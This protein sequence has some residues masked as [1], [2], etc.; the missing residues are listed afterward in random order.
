VPDAGPA[1]AAARATGFGHRPGLDGLRAWAVLAVLAFHSG[2]LRAGWVGVDVFFALSG[3]LI[4][5]LLLAEFERTG[6]VSLR[7]F[8]GRRARRLLPALAL[9]FL[10]VAVGTA[11]TPGSWVGATAA[12]VWGSATYTANWVR[13]AGDVG[14]WDQFRAPGPLEH[15]WSLA[16]EE[17]FYVVWPV[18]MV[19]VLRRWGRRGAVRLA[20]ATAVTTAAVQ[21]GLALAGAGVER[22]YVGTDTRA[23]AFA[24]GAWCVLAA[25][26]RVTP[27]SRWRRLAA[28]G[29]G[30]GLAGLL[31]ACLL[32]DGDA[33]STYLGP[34][35]ITSVVGALTV[36]A[37]AHAGDGR[38]AHVVT[39]APLR[40]IGRWSY[41]IYLYHWPVVVVLRDWE[42]APAVRFAVVAAVATLLAALSYELVEH[43]IRSGRLRLRT[44]VPSTATAIA[45]AGVATVA[46]AG[47]ALADAG[48]AAQRLDDAEVAELLAPLGGAPDDGL[49]GAADDPAGP[50]GEATVTTLAPVPVLQTDRVL[51]AGDSVPFHL[52]SA[53]ETAAAAAGLEV[54]VR[55]A[56]GCVPSPL[57]AD[58]YRAENDELCARL[59]E[60]LPR[61]LA[62]YRPATLVVYY[63]LSGPEVREG[64]RTYDACAP[65]GRSALTAQL[66]RV[67]AAADGIG[68]K[69][70]LVPPL[71]P[72]EVDFVDR[73]AQLAGWRC[74]LA[75]YDAFGAD[76]PEVQVVP[77]LDLLCPELRCRRELFGVALFRDG[78]HY[79]ADGAEAV[80]PWLLDQ[81]AV[82]PTA[83]RG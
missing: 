7:R 9:V 43:P 28:P 17:Q 23:P 77:I 44:L 8:W 19:L 27:A 52:R 25:D 72:P 41:G 59:V 75:T 12:D 36:L 37:A 76:H 42:V 34:L 58:Q 2:A 53:L 30:A 32:L 49:P 22:L 81:V 35:L 82:R 40:W 26:P 11:T 39:A 68:T 73:D 29:V 16:V 63:G 71:E 70:A 65:D 14:Y 4:T 69:V 10:V 20:A 38:L 66:R 46:L 57:V 21:V 56:P 67:L 6:T 5:G 83:G 13:L 61:D 60:Q 55:A 33:R 50:A 1:G 3:F 51:V 74:Y 24:V 80:A 62:T 79:S 45:V 18:L 54:A 15:M 78:I 47:G 64:G 48:L 31:A